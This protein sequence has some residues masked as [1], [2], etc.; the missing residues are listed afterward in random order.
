MYLRILSQIPNAIL[1]LLRFPDLG[2]QNLLKF[3]RKWAGDGTASRIIFTDVAPK[4]THITRAS[5]VDLFLDTPEC[6]AHTTAA[7]VVWSGTPII[8]WGRWD[9]KMCSRMAGSIVAS[10]LPIG[11]EGDE[12]REDLMV[13]S[14]VQYEEQAIKLVGSLKYPTEGSLGRGKGRL[15]E[16]RKLLWEGRWSNRLFDTRRWVRDV[17]RAYWTAW[18]KW[19]AGE[20]GDIWL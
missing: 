2:E 7:D 12:A 4:G 13:N 15:M 20:G 3:A 19:E 16:L 9:Y 1:W 5:V 10:A 14:D 8:T 17:E 6:N 11:P 18:K